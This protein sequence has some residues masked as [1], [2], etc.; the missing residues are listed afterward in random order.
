MIRLAT[1][2]VLTCILASGCAEPK[3]F[4]VKRPENTQI[5][6]AVTEMWTNE[7]ASVARDGDWI[8]TRSY[9][10]LADAI[11][12]IAPGEDLSHA[13]IYDAKTNTIV[14]A[15]NAGIRELPLQA[16]V[17]RNHYVI[18]VRPRHVTAEEGTA[19]VARARTK[20]GVS[21][22]H[23]GFFGLQNDEKFYCSELVWWASHGEAKN[24]VHETI[25]TPANLMQYGEVVYWSGKR[26]DAQ[27]QSLALDRSTTPRAAETRTATR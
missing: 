20:I 16:L 1:V 8:L 12:T 9:Y 19:A 6:A 11:T 3:S 5:D 26:D 14:E 25:I 23:M 22:D 27:V 21:F 2:T 4:L 13:S 18:V 7:I 10:W 15:V 24:G 17:Q